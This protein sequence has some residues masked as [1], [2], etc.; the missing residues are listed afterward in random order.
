MFSMNK[1]RPIPEL[2]DDRKKLESRANANAEQI[3][4]FF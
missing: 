2:L 4:R 3:G 1:T